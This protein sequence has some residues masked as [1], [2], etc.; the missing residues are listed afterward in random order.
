MSRHTLPPDMT[1]AEPRDCL[2][3]FLF[4]QHQVRG[5]L[6][7]LNR[8]VETA[9]STH[10]Y[11]AVTAALLG[12]ALGAVALLTSI[13]KFKG[14]L[15]LQ[16]Q[17]DGPLRLLVAQCSHHL[18]VRGLAQGDVP[19]DAASAL[20]ELTTNGRVVM[21]IEPE[22]GQ[23]YQGIVPLEGDSLAGCL[24]SYF[25]RSEQLPTR[26]WLHAVKGNV[27]G[28]LLQKL[29]GEGAAASG[30]RVDQDAWNRLTLL[31]D[32]L[33]EEEMHGLSDEQ[34]LHRLFHE[35]DVR[36]F[37]R[38]PVMFRCSCSRERVGA[39]LRGIGRAD[40]EALIAEQGTISTTC[41]FCNRSYE[42]DRV[43]VGALFE[44]SAGD[45]SSTQH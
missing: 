19:A 26:L 38:E 41:E 23:R 20:S 40:A 39:A 32:T 34:I 27:F 37:D 29:P 12:E 17:S 35:E 11:D 43:D 10:A 9:L 42:F 44:P 4:E 36:V 45:A 33:A 7:H 6:I 16:L 18:H 8:S 22:E 2:R 13:L 24:E 31:A 15:T 3:R 5:E 14:R 28:M 1:D 30:A 25:E 21:T